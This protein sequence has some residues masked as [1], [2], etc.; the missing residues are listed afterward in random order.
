MWGAREGSREEVSFHQNLK[1]MREPALQ[2]PGRRAFQAEKQKMKRSWN[3]NMLGALERHRVG[4]EAGVQCA[5]AERRRRG[6]VVMLQ[7][8][9]LLSF[10]ALRLE[11]AQ[12]MGTRGPVDF[13][14]HVHYIC[15]LP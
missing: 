4:R 13:W 11:P 9:K 14:G 5:G 15:S 1:E 3:G 10:L 6:R 7:S 2:I 8:T 12:P